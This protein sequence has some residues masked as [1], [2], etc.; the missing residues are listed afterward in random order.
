MAYS[1]NNQVNLFGFS[2]FRSWKW[3]KINKKTDQQEHRKTSK[4]ISQD[5]I[6]HLRIQNVQELSV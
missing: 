5:H 4:R 2:Y 1:S 6:K 3:I